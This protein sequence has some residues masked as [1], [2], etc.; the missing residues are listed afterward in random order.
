M[1]VVNIPSLFR[2]TAT[3]ASV[4]VNEKETYRSRSIPAARLDVP[5]HNLE[6]KTL[7]FSCQKSFHYYC[8]LTATV[9]VL[10]LRLP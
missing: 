8:L 1:T 6:H 10:L 7:Q 3:G 9:L 2:I 5:D 4:L